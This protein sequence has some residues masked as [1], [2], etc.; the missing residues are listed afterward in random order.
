LVHL[1]LPSMR[2]LKKGLTM[3]Q[4]P[5]LRRR[6][7]LT[8]IPMSFEEHAQAYRLPQPNGLQKDE[9]NY[10][11]ALSLYSS[12]KSFSNELPVTL[13]RKFT[14]SLC[15]K[16]FD[17]PSALETHMNSHTGDRPFECTICP[18]RF[19][20]RSNMLRHRKQHFIPANRMSI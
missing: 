2:S 17:R 16:G 12:I 3:T 15:N 10:S 18:S 9:R 7:Y 14:C 11:P 13:T 5:H 8:S 20:V 19:S 4:N 6:I 1:I